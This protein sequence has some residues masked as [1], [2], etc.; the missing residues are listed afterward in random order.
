[1][2]KIFTL[3]ASLVLVLNVNATPFKALYVEAVAQESGAGKVYLAA[4]STEDEGYVYDISEEEGSTAFIKWVAGENSD[5]A[6][7]KIG[8][9]KQIGM[10]E[11]LIHA[12]PAD[13]YELVCYAD[14]VKE[15]GIYTEDDCYAII[16][17]EN[18]S[19][20]WSFDFDFTGNGDKINVNNV[21]HPQDG[22]SE[23]GPSRDDVYAAFEDYVSETPD[24]YVYVI[25]RKI[26][27]ELPKFVPSDETGI[28][29]AKV[30]VAGQDA[31]YSLTGQR[32]SKA[33][34][35]IAIQNGKK[36]VVK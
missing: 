28:T 3:M 24:T 27:D 20:G 17:G 10:Y 18:A 7:L 4:K 33:V 2:K 23:D 5:G 29:E 15:D 6:D 22:H 19:G 35:G 34:T 8:C 21:D 9:T 16:H 12:F 14:K 36:V 31:V 30:A 13:G 11:V 1:M 25:F 26:G 32:L